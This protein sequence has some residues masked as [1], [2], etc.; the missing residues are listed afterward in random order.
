[1]GEEPCSAHRDFDEDGYGQEEGGGEKDI[2]DQNWKKN[3]CVMD[4]FC[5]IEV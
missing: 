5:E 3:P 1:V 4:N 2:I